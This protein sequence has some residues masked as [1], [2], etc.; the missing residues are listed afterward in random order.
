MPTLLIASYQ[1]F[2]SHFTLRHPLVSLDLRYDQVFNCLRSLFPWG[3]VLLSNSPT[4]KRTRALEADEF[5]PSIVP[6]PPPSKRR[7]TRASIAVDELQPQSGQASHSPLRR[8]RRKRTQEVNGHQVQSGQASSPPQPASPKRKPDILSETNL[9]I[10]NEDMDSVASSCI[11]RSSSSS[12]RSTA[13]SDATPTQRF[14]G[15]AAHYRQ[16][17]LTAAG[18][19]V[20]THPPD[21]IHV[22]INSI[23]SPNPSKERRSI[24]RIIAQKFLDGCTK[25]VRAA[26]GED[27][28]VDLLHDA[29]LAM[30]HKR[31]CLR[32]KADWREELKPTIQPSNFNFNFLAGNQQQ[33]VDDSAPLPKRQQ[34]GAGSKYVSPQTS[35]SDTMESAPP[36]QLDSMLPPP[37]IKTPRPDFS[38]GIQDTDLYSVLSSQNLTSTAAWQL[39]A[40]LKRL[41]KRRR[42]DGPEEPLLIAAPAERAS[43]LMFP[44]IVVEGKAYS[45]GKQI[46][47]AENQAAVSGAC[48]LKIQLC[49]DELVENST[50]SDV[51][52]VAVL[53]P[54][55]PSQTPPL[56]FSICTEGP[57][58]Q[59]WAHYTLFEDGVR[60][61]NMYILTVCNGTLLESLLDFFIKVDNVLQWGTGAFLDSIAE[62]LGKVAKRAVSQKSSS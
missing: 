13:A 11:K 53:D 36:K 24:L 9:Q 30:D 4:R 43:D 31:L 16:N 40:N 27:D 61:Y 33:E 28:C 42:Q 38:L 46:C 15:T 8:P 57:I 12:R 21:N 39:L 5:Q 23:V 49:L 35:T 62:R 60:K 1:F 29:I 25:T 22:V 10:F 47:E 3:M 44:F 58:H 19:H 59:L 20:Y 34:Q 7:R 41:M 52:A 6:Q 45:T 2:I 50:V 37:F 26:V 55:V 51:P 17:H 56:F 18:V 48:G 32:K 14:S 54:H